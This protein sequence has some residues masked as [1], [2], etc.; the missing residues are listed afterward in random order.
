MVEVLSEFEIQADPALFAM[1][2][3]PRSVGAESFA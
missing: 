3:L 1:G 2:L